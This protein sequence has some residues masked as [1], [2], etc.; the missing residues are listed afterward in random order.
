VILSPVPEKGETEKM[1]KGVTIDPDEGMSESS[2]GSSTAEE[3]ERN[4]ELERERLQAAL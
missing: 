2:I 1:A 4:E 3:Q